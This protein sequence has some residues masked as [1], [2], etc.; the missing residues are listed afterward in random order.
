MP[1]TAERPIEHRFRT[2][3]QRPHFGGQN[4]DVVRVRS[5]RNHGRILPS[6]ERWRFVREAEC[7]EGPASGEPFVCTLRP[8]ERYLQNFLTWLCTAGRYCSSAD[9]SCCA[10]FGSIEP[11]AATLICAV[12]KDASESLASSHCF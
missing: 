12:R 9:N 8:G 6:G 11:P 10:V 2:G 7:D 4:G 1:S 3:E 5:E